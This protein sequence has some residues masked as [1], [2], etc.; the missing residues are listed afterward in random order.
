MKKKI[1]LLGIIALGV[2]AFFFFDLGRFLSLE[3]LKTHRNDL[4]AYY[5]AN[6][7]LMILGYIGVYIATTALS[8]PGATLLTLLGGALFGAVKGTFIV[9]IGATCGATLA[10]FAA[11]FLLKDWVQSRFGEKL[12]TFQAGLE[13]NAFNYML[14]LRLVPLF[15]F[16]LVNLASGMT[17]IPVKTFFF[18]TMIGTL[19]GTFVYANAGS[20]LAAINSLKDIASP[21]VIGAFVLLGLFALVPTLYQKFMKRKNQSSPA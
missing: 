3:A 6:P 18:G 9:N 13:Q 17:R 7:V 14:F 8:L 15:P 4:L 11:R 2:A 20:N 16:F 21:Q 5:E 10:F 12:K 1:I 19:P